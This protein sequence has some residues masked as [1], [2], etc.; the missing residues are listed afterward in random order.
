MASRVSGCLGKALSEACKTSSFLFSSG[1]I[2]GGLS[3]ICF[4]TSLRL[5]GIA[6]V[7]FMPEKFFPW[8]VDFGGIV[9]AAFISVSFAKLFFLLPDQQQPQVRSHEGV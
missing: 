9:S 3:L 4:S 2:S 6:R 1:N 5:A 7:F 8:P